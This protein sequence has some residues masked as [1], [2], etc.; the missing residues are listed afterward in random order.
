MLAILTLINEVI[1]TGGPLAI[2]GIKAL[3]ELAAEKGMTTAQLL[4]HAR[5]VHDIDTAKIE[6]LLA[7]T[8]P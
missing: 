6:A 7:E 2:L 5:S 4:A 1:N 8:Q 3:H